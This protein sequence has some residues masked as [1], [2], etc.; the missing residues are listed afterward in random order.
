MT[1]LFCLCNLSSLNQIH[2]LHV[3]YCMRN[4]DNLI[5]KKIV[6]EFCKKYNIKLHYFE[7]DSNYQIN[8]NFQNDARVYRYDLANSIC[9]KYNL[10]SFLTAHNLNDYIETYFIKKLQ[11]RDKNN[12]SINEQTTYKDTLVLRPLINVSKKNIYDYAQENKI[13]WNEDYTNKSSKYLRNRIRKKINKID[14]FD[15]SILHNWKTKIQSKQKNRVQ[16]YLIGQ[17]IENILKLHHNDLIDAISFTLNKLKVFKKSGFIN[18]VVKLINVNKMYS[19]LILDENTILVKNDKYLQI[20]QFEKKQKLKTN[21][22]VKNQLI[23]FN[24]KKIQFNFSKD[25][26][27]TIRYK[28]NG[29]RI[30]KTEGHK[31]LVQELK[32]KKIQPWIKDDLIVVEID[33]KIVFVEKVYQNSFIILINN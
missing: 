22:V 4:E 23:E 17:E 8:N 27:V 19:S 6:E 9:K 33:N 15:N 28:Q 7:Y 10:D 31:R 1:L 2:V 29:D 26:N 3:N 18:E 24:N 16:N 32:D 30:L 12:L 21:I 13:L 20:Y 5:E 25:V 11:N 14:E